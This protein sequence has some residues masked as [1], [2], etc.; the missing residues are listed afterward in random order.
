MDTSFLLVSVHKEVNGQHWSCW[1][2][3]LGGQLYLIERNDHD[4]SDGEICCVVG[5]DG[6]PEDYAYMG[7]MRYAEAWLAQHHLRLSTEP[8]PHI[9][10]IRVT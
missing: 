5:Q 1:D 3:T 2:V 10:H 7:D 9:M 4:H 6:E 8:D